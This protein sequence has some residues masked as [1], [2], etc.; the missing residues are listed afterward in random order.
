MQTDST[1]ILQSYK[2]STIFSVFQSII[3]K[4]NIIKIACKNTEYND[5]D[6]V[7]MLVSNNASEISDM[8][9]F[10]QSLFS[11]T[12]KAVPIILVLKQTVAIVKFNE[13]SFASQ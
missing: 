8:T 7:F 4:L 11:K 6:K 3:L 12:I 2:F 9:S 10:D 1:K 5:K 13:T